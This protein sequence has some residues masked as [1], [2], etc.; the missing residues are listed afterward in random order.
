MGKVLSYPEGTRILSLQ[1]W[2]TQIRQRGYL[3]FSGWDYVVF[4]EFL[5][6]DAKTKN[7]T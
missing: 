1:D 7:I 4:Y 3:L 6:H 5:D 2:A